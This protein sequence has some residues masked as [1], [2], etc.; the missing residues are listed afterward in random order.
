[1]CAVIKLYYS[2]LHFIAEL[3]AFKILISAVNKVS[4]VCNYI[5]KIISKYIK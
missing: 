4:L 2:T 1:M 5:T 3:I